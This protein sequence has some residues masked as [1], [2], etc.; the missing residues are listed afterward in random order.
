MI[1]PFYWLEIRIR[2]R[3]KR[4][5]IIALFFLLS[6]FLFGGGI[7]AIAVVESVARIVPGDLGK[8]ITTTLLF[9][10]GAILIVMA[11]LASAGRLAQEREQRTLP[12]LINTTADPRRIVYGKLLGAW[13]FILWLS[14]LILP[15]LVIGAVWGG[16]PLWKVAAPLVINILISA[17]LSS[18]ALGF[19]GLF[20]RSLTA[21][22]VAGAFMLAWIVVLPILGGIATE[23]AGAAHAGSAR[24]IIE[25]ACF[26]HHPFYPSILIVSD[27]WKMEP[28]Q[29]TI[30]LAYC[31]F[32]W[33]IL[34][35]AG[36]WMARRGLQKEVF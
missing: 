14:A 28:A 23:L 15:F 34:T 35:V 9:W 30:R 16:M 10:H 18:I 12:A 33:T 8:G 4:L 31:L 3:E 13:T 21:Y 5:W 7:L 27:A 25:W 36:I 2:A 6:V 24:H 17:V 22:L 32:I 19:S 11:P 29:S 26:Y 20:G 1:N